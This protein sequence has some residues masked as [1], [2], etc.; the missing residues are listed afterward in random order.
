[1]GKR[2]K[3]AMLSGMHPGSTLTPRGALLKAAVS[4]MIN[5]FFNSDRCR[6]LQSN[7]SPVLQPDWGCW[8]L[9]G[10]W[11]MLEYAIFPIQ[12]N[13]CGGQDQE[14]R[15]DV[16]A[17]G[18][19]PWAPNCSWPIG[20]VISSTVNGYIQ[21]YSAKLA[22]VLFSSKHDGQS[23]HRKDMSAH[24]GAAEWNSWKFTLC[25][26][27]ASS[28]WIQVHTGFRNVGLFYAC[29]SYICVYIYI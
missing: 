11:C 22:R 9:N 21:S 20:S 24:S 19:K 3:C 7:N 26:K 14:N 16:I 27:F 13:I 15:A 17:L 18:I 23:A 5:R 8:L 6:P 4:G 2:E 28:I 25:S 1:M 10:K 12:G 29:F